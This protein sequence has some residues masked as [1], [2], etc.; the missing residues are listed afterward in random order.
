VVERYECQEH[1]D[2]DDRDRDQIADR[3]P[4]FRL[5]AARARTTARRD[6]DPVGWG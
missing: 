6:E 5:L 3:H 1:G 4:M 2:R